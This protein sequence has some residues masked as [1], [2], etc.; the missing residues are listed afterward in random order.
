MR[1]FLARR[2]IYTML[3]LLAATAVVVALSRM[4]GD[5]RLLTPRLRA[6]TDSLQ[7]SM[8]PWVRNWGWT[9]L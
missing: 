6:G 3:S 1:A 2:L 4:A 8:R 5:P 7:S 9:S